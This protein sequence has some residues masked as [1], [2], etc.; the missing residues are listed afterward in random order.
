MSHFGVLVILKSMKPNIEDAVERALAPFSE[1][2]EVDEHEVTC[3]CVG[4]QAKREAHV[5]ANSTLYDLNTERTRMWTDIETMPTRPSE[6]VI[7]QM[8]EK[9]LNPWFAAEKHALENHPLKLAADKNC[10]EC[11]GTG[12][13]MSDRNPEGYWDWYQ[14]GGRWTG[15]LNPEY[16]PEKDPANKEL[17][18]D[19]KLTT[20]WPTSWAKY[21]G[22]VQR[23]G[24]ASADTLSKAFF[25]VV[26]PDGKWHTQGK[27]GW[28]GTSTNNM[29]DEQWLAHLEQLVTEHLGE[30]CVV[31]DCHS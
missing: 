23:V 30:T 10:D 28:F 31:V 20:K 21:D 13:H 29:T 22:D 4:Q 12:K 11:S 14:I 9:I 8:W 18:P 24:I 17:G 19:G 3:W 16:K 7:Q 25:A 27:M 5:T 2:K 26:T 15:A 1:N 6:E